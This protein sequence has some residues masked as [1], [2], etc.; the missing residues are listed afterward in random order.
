MR[1]EKGSKSIR[2]GRAALVLLGA[3]LMIGLLP[4][5][6][7][8][9]LAA[10]VPELTVTADA[11]SMV[12][13]GDL[14]SYTVTL[15]NSGHAPAVDLVITHVLPEGFAY[16]VGS[17]EVTQNGRLISS[18]D[19]LVDGRRLMW[20]P[21]TMP[22]AL[23]VF[24]NAYGIHSFVQDLCA[25]SYIDFQLYKALELAGMGGH[26]T[27]LL[28]PV[29]VST[30]G[31]KSCWMYFVNR[32]YDLNLVPVVRIQG[33]WAGDRWLKPEADGLGDY[34]S[35]AAAFK[36]VVE[37]LPR[38]DGHTLY[39]QIWNE[40]NLDVEWSTEG[41][42]WGPA[43]PYEYARFLVDVAAA[44]REIADPRI[45]I[46]NGALAPGGN[47]NNLEFI[48]AMAGV[49]GAVEAFDVWASHPYPKNH[50][51]E[52]N[53]HDGT[54]RYQQLTIDSYLLELQALASHGGRT[55]VKVLLTET[56]YELY[57]NTYGFE[58]YPRIGERNRARYITRAFTD[59]WLSWPEVI[60]VTPFELVDPY[61]SWSRWDW[62]YPTTDAPHR[63]FT[64]VM[65]LPKPDPL[66]VIPLDM[67]IAFQARAP[68]DPG[69]YYSDIVATAS[70]TDILPLTGVAP[71]MVVEELHRVYLPL[72]AQSSARPGPVRGIEPE[73]AD[74]TGV[75]L[76]RLHLSLPESVP[77][78]GP[79]VPLLSPARW[80]R[81]PV[82]VGRV[83]VGSNPEGLDLD[84]SRQ[85]AYVTLGSGDLVIIDTLHYRVL[86]TI[87]V[88]S[89]PRGVAAN[90]ASGLIYVANSGDGTLSVVDAQNHRLVDTIGGFA[91]PVALAVDEAANQVY[92]TDGGADSLVVVD[93]D[94]NRIVRRV[95]VGSFPH[96]VVVDHEQERVY[97]ANA[98]DGTV[99][100]IEGTKLSAVSTIRIGQGPVL[101][102]AVDEVEGRL[103]VVYLVSAR[104]RGIAVVDGHR[105]EVTA[106]FAGGWDLPLE[107]LY[108]V[109]VNE[110]KDRI[111]MAGGRDV[112]MVDLERQAVIGALSLEAV[113]YN[114]GLAVDADRG[115]FY[116]L[117]SS[118]G[119]LL[120]LE[121]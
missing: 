72:L 17:S 113:T 23:G 83:S 115:R 71:V 54:A 99:S 20:G 92:V 64:A 25:E 1:P 26:V 4:V 102:M 47:Y 93:G 21:F 82:L 106:A 6:P 16:D 75:S 88:G 119:A 111:Y 91:R 48:A 29:T 46:L 112:L 10:L 38:R 19:P 9:S 97:V 35:S 50:P 32:A 66:E 11:E 57:D 121:D 80:T 62:L 86:S 34:S 59:F 58:G 30:D 105:M 8:V 37:G 12:E 104:R 78:P 85:R 118:S 89:Q 31:P 13:T 103:Y 67:V 55:G 76:D 39:V 42:P 74:E 107:G 22:G 96:H 90:A 114:L 73:D 79:V 28:Y 98:G 7:E 51:P 41:G 43:N 53:I 84:P 44:I 95:A 36:R 101:G 94:T 70:N 40:P 81:A 33:E 68:I 63:Q 52:Y 87:P 61:G 117:D 49:E 116:M 65:G 2:V 69:T 60:G 18:S 15:T 14:V 56:G 5:G 108:A 27:Q 24:D 120:A 77:P 45:V 109:A 3:I 100:V 110:E